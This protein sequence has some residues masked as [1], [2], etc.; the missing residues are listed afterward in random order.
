MQTEFRK[1]HYCLP[2]ILIHKYT[3]LYTREQTPVQMCTGKCVHVWQTV[4]E[5]L[6]L[7]KPPL[8]THYNDIIMGA[9][10]SQITSLAIV[11]SSFIQTQIKENI[12]A[13][14]HWPLCG[15][16]TGTGEF[17]AQMASYA[18]N[19]SIW[20]RHREWRQFGIITALNSH[21]HVSKGSLNTDPTYVRM[22]YWIM[23]TQLPLANKYVSMH[24]VKRYAV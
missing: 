20:W 6:E 9:I 21:E 15:E 18:E 17:T 10:A 12:K 22:I 14:R 4:A 16:F 5:T 11:F 13:P 7:R 2:P 19:I 8:P 23:E 24:S 1:P 3:C